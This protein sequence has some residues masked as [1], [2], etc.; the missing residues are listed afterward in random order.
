MPLFTPPKA[1]VDDLKRYDKDLRVV[2]SDTR[3]CWLIQRKISHAKPSLHGVFPDADEYL[4]ARDGYCILFEVDRECLDSRV[5]YSLWDTDIWRQGG[6]E[7]VNERI[8]KAY[9][10]AQRQGRE[11]FLDMVRQEARSRWRYMHR[12]RLLPENKVHTAPEGG[13][14]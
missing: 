12:P 4:A 13:M 5:L 3:A 10:S 8:D 6:A 2:W 14:F 11:E 9:F 1:F 7:V